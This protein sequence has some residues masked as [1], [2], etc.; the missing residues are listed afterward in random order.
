MWL[1]LSNSF[2]SIAHEGTDPDK[3]MVRARFRTDITRVFPGAMITPTP[4]RDYPFRAYI[5]RAVVGDT[6]ANAVM[7]I[8]YA[9]FK[10]QV[11]AN[12]P[13]RHAA[14]MDVWGVLY[15]WQTEVTGKP[16][17]FGMNWPV[18]SPRIAYR[19]FPDPDALN[20]PSDVEGCQNKGNRRR[21]K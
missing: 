21:R 6:I 2:L 13:D 8:D 9:K 10:P 15:N 16:G 5:D 17:V 19:G 7:D 12:E 3:L 4:N 1:F 20:F 14:Y 18:Q 11:P